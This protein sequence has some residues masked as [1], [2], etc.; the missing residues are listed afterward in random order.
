V[1]EAPGISVR[2]NEAAFSF[3][4]VGAG[5]PRPPKRSWTFSHLI[6]VAAKYLQEHAF[7]SFVLIW[8]CSGGAS[9]NA[10]LRDGSG[11]AKLRKTEA[12]H[13]IEQN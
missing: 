4:C 7:F 11:P 10:W 13:L 1:S 6:V 12:R 5:W 8:R 9:I 2:D 3:T